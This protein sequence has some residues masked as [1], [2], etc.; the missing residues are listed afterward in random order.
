MTWAPEARPQTAEEVRNAARYPEV[1]EAAR[2]RGITSIVH[3]TR[4]GGLVGIL[5]SSAVK[6]RRDLMRDTRLKYVAEEERARPESGHL[7]AR[8]R[9]HVRHSDQQTHVPVLGAR[10]SGRSVGDPRVRPGDPR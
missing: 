1:V 6:A 2:E 8:L 4:I 3:F 7:V 10:A 9:Q 5:A